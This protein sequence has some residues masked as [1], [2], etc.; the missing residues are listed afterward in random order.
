MNYGSVHVATADSTLSI[1]SNRYSQAAGTTAVNSSLIIGDFG[2]TV[3]GVV[4]VT[5]GNLFVTNATMNGL[6]EVRSGTLTLNA[7][8]LTVDKLV[9]TNACARFIHTGGAL[10]TNAAALIDPDMDADGDGLPNSFELSYGLDPFDPRDA[11]QDDG[12]GDTPKSPPGFFREGFSFCEAG[13][14][15]S[16]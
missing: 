4:E 7:G 10:V 2:C 1:G 13:A 5:G 15:L 16:R 12:S 11:V 6:L 14:G 3:T 9:I 8:G